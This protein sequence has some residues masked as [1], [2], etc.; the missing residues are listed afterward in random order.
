MLFACDGLARKPPAACWMAASGR[1]CQQI[2]VH[3]CV[4]VIVDVRGVVKGRAF[5]DAAA[6]QSFCD[7]SNASL[8]Q[9]YPE[10]RGDYLKVVACK[11]NVPRG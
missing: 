6:A 8:R 3:D 9:A 1:K 4:F 10:I 2:T 7:D 11:L 5:D